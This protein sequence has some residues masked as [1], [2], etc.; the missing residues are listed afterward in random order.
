MLSKVLTI[1]RRISKIIAENDD[2]ALILDEI[3]KVLAKNLDSEVCSIYVF[4]DDREQLVLT[5]TFGLNKDLIGKLKLKPG[6]GITGAA[7]K[8]GEIVNV[9][10]PREHP[11][12][13]LVKGSGEEKYKSFLSVP[14]NVG[15]RHVGVL[16]LQKINDEPFTPSITD[17]V[18]SVCTQIA[19]LIIS[20]KML[21]ELATDSDEAQAE[22]S[23]KKKQVVIRGV[24]ANAGIA[25]GNAVLF[26]K[27]DYFA[28]IRPERTLAQAKEVLLFE[29]ALKTARKE[30]AEL[31]TKAVSLISEADAS[32]FD[33][34]ILFLDDKTLLDAIKQK[35]N[36][37]YTVE[38]SLKFVND[39]YQQRFSR[40]QDQVFREKA[41]D[42]K[43]ILLRILK[44]VMAMR[45]G[46]V[47]SDDI[48]VQSRQIIFTNELLPS[49]LFRMPIDRIAGIVTEK[50]GATAHVALL[51]KALNI[52]TI[53][54]ARD[55]LE[56]VRAD[57]EVILDCHAENVYIRPTENVKSH[58]KDM[59]QL[60]SRESEED[61]SDE[62]SVTSDGR[63][64]SLRGNISLISETSILKKYGAKGIG[65]YRTEF[66]FMIRDFMPAED[67]QFQV[68]SKIF[69]EVKDD[70]VTIRVLDI[71]ADKALPYLNFVKEDNPVLG[72]RGIRVLL[73]QKELM[74]TQLRAI[75]RAGAAGKLRILFPMISCV[76]QIIEARQVL[77]EV[78]SELHAK[79]IPHSDNYK[80]GMMLEVPSVI[81]ALDEF[82]EYVDYM[83]IGT[84]D[85][86]QYTFAVDRGNEQVAYLFN[87]LHPSFLKML[88][89]I[90]GAFRS[91]GDK[92]LAICGEMAGNI[93]AVP[94]LL[95]AGIID[96]SMAPRNIPAV[97]KV[98]RAFT[99]Y[100]CVELLEK[101]V[102]LGNPEAVECLIKQEFSKKGL[103]S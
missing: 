42:L 12:F 50:G 61:Y 85:L 29:H 46:E 23:K 2:Q 20:S 95:G 87:P 54:G 24:S 32:I 93:Y 97:R 60:S 37:G 56:N 68:Y 71:G 30:I 92:S 64:I 35:I 82:L 38:S 47:R 100:E 103:K 49:D 27:T 6:E 17:V 36:D 31:S 25:I 90:S 83:S 58:F 9:A 22:V 28:E 40:L 99:M 3:V 77:S 69:K 18:K 79:N 48:E 14:L 65:L 5:A 98:I 19:N 102:G 51:A 74:K 8:S 63:E 70:E 16:N 13:K 1:L 76:S 91:R 101:V 72:W 67:A 86:I 81:F 66:L 11:K 41:L 55:S 33:V 15:G 94:F 39:D 7:F 52:P 44:I 96:L 45:S 73:S 88:K 75:L 10:N 53:L 84:N 26:A 21:K 4:N 59:I 89:F 34:H 78:E 80:V 62:P 57:D 43:D